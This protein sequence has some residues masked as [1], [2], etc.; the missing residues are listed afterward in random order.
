[1]SVRRVPSISR[2]RRAGRGGAESI[3][4]CT[5]VERR[6]PR[7]FVSSFAAPR[8]DS[9]GFS[10]SARAQLSIPVRP[11][12]RKVC[13]SA[14]FQLFRADGLASAR[15]GMLARLLCPMARLP[16]PLANTLSGTLG[17]VASALS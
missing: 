14:L 12:T 11:G 6:W 8:P 2:E 3:S 5:K 10:R 7:P 16:T 9:D 4:C 17:A 13:Q 1:M 15:C